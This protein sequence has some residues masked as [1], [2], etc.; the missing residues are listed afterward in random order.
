MEIKR[1]ILVLHSATDMYELVHD[2]ASY[3]NFLSWCLDARVLD[4]TGE[5][6]LASLDVAIAGINQSFTTRNLLAPGKSLTM[7]LERGPFRQLEG[8]WQFEPLGKLGS[9][10]SLGLTFDFASSLLS[11]AFRR[12]FAKVADQL[13]YDF[14]RRA[15]EV[16]GD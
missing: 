15:D 16:Y 5:I 3:P 7:E 4:Q 13:V 14:S 1:T 2:V 10:V 9:K 12:G 8:Q 6:Q 11:S